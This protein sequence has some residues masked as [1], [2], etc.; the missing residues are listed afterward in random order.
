MGKIY[1]TLQEFF[2]SIG[3]PLSQDT[4]LTVHLLKGLHG[5]KLLQSPWFRTNYYTFLLITKGKGK[6]SIDRQTFDLGKDSF[7][8]TNP[9]H[10]KSFQMQELMEGYM[11]TFSEKFVKQHFT[12][13]FFQLFPF[14]VHE[15][16]PVMYLNKAT[17]E[18]V[19]L[20]FEQMLKEYNGTSFY[21]NAILT[22]QL[23]IL[24]LKTKEL[25]FSHKA[26]IKPPNRS[27]TLVSEF[28][29]LL[30]ENFRQLAL[31]KADKIF[32]VKEFAHQLNI[33]PNYLTNL[34]KEETGKSA[35]VWIHERTLSEAQALLQSEK[36]IS[37]VAY[38]LG[39]ADATHFAKFF[40]KHTGISPSSFKKNVI[41]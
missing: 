9:G 12:G 40:K 14:L 4:E 29:N 11:L 33:H 34:V 21:K 30:N 10:L 31:S 32:S 25:L 2:K 37:E 19:S 6:Y 41:I 7:Y 23:S 15:T 20:I 38:M 18:E 16:T 27:A 39:F 26:I 35:S 28:K 8:F 24:L 17:S 36:N 3:L 5:D 22:H 13:D 1:H